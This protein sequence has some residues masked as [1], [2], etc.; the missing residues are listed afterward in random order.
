MGIHRGEA[1]TRKAIT[2]E[3]AWTPITYTLRL[4]HN[5]GTDGYTDQT[6]TYDQ[7]AS[8]QSVSRMGYVFTGWNT[9]ADG[10]GISYA[11]E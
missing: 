2:F 4:H 7:T 10:N 11:D 6:L 5:D 3:A 8:I 1:A 9:Q